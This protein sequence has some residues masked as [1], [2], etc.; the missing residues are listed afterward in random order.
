MKDARYRFWRNEGSWDYDIAKQVI[1]EYE[2]QDD[3]LQQKQYTNW[4]IEYAA[5]GLIEAVKMR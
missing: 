2:L 1:D 5:N 3:R 4:L